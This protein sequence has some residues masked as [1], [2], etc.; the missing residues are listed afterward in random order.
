MVKIGV[1][2]HPV[3]ATGGNDNDTRQYSGEEKAD[4]DKFLLQAQPD[5]I[6]VLNDFSWA[7]RFAIMLPNT[8]VIFRKEH[9]EDGAFWNLKHENGQPYTPMDHFIGTKEH[10]HPKIMLNLSNEGM[11][12][13]VYFDNGKPNYDAILKMS[14]WLAECMDLFGAAGVPLVVP[15]WGVGL[16]DLSWF[17]KSAPEWPLIRPLIEAFKRWPIHHLGIH[18]YWCKN[19]FGVDDFLHRPIDLTAALEELEYDPIPMQITEYGIDAIGG[20]PGPWQE[21]YGANDDG[22]NLYG[23]LLVRGQ[24]TIYNVPYIRGLMVFCWGSYPRWQKYDISKAKHVQAALIGSNQN[25]AVDN[26]TPTPE[27]TPPY[28][29]IPA[30][31]SGA[32]EVTINNAAYPLKATPNAGTK[33][34]VGTLSIGERVTL[35]RSTHTLDSRFGSAFQYHWCERVSTPVGES[36]Y[37]WTAYPM[38]VPPPPPDPV[39][40]ITEV[41]KPSAAD[42]ALIKIAA[43]RESIAIHHAAILA[44]EAQIDELLEP[45]KSQAA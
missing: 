12:K 1:Q 5:S 9:K 23:S 3:F 27:P 10:H 25:E 21:A 4:L 28:V 24:R 8:R 14:T 45:Y 37:G 38:P 6:I 35:Y 26:Q 34:T 43:C 22:E 30:D 13:T 40:P 42:T 19:R 15:N 39:P 2:I 36:P 7:T 29:P 16:P 11:G 44:L 32:V 31:L 33:D 41:P 18:T 20:I 17:K